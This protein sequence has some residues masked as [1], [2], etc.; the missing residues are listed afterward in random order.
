M[1]EIP[2]NKFDST[3][4]DYLKDPESLFRDNYEGLHQDPENGANTHVNMMASVHRL[5][6]EFFDA[7]RCDGDLIDKFRSHELSV[8]QLKN[9][10]RAFIDFVEE[11]AKAIDKKT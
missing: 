6:V 5:I 2:E 7:G 11:K 1:N 3:D 10:S 9:M 8:Q 4:Q